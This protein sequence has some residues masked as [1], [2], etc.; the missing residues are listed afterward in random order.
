MNEGALI[1]VIFRD[2]P[3]DSVITIVYDV[4]STGWMIGLSLL[5]KALEKGKL[6]IISNYNQT[7]SHLAKSL[8]LVGTDMWSEL[9]SNNLVIFDIFGSRYGVRERYKNVFYL[10]NVDPETINPKIDSMYRDHILP[11]I[12]NRKV[13]RLIY[14]LD[15]ATLILGENVTLKLLNQTIAA[16]SKLLKGSIL[17]LPINSDVVSK[18]FTAWVVGISDYALVVRSEFRDDKI[19]EFLH[20]IRAPEED[21]EPTTYLLTTVGER[22]AERLRV[23][24]LTPELG[25]L[26]KQ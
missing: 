20:L 8:N 23:K 24:K 1:D 21:F 14:T 2:V 12:N 7:L 13:V 18:R 9:N 10:D 5:K 6:G 11:M 4:H 22:K 3:E 19:M 15:G 26:R 17:I 25:S 16:K